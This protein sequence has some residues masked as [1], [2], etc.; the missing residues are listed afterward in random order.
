MANEKGVKK[1]S[2][3]RQIIIETDGK[4]VNLAKAEV[5]GVIELVA[6]L[7]MVINFVQNQ[8]NSPAKATPE[9]A[10]P[11]VESAKATKASK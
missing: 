8:D 7:N 5:Y 9:E 10:T 3:V 1:V 2:T 11:A 4:N 6:I